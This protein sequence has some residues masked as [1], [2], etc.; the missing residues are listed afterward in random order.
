MVS[1]NAGACTEE[2]RSQ[3]M[4]LVEGMLALTS[5]VDAKLKMIEEKEH[6]QERMLARVDSN[7]R[8]AK[9]KV[10][11]NVGGRVFTASRD[12]F[13]RYENTYFHALFGCHCW[14]PDEDGTFFVDRDPTHF[15]RIMKSLRSGEPIDQTGLSSGEVENVHQEIEYY[16]LP[17]L[18]TQTL[19]RWNSERCTGG[20]VITEDGRTV[21][22]TSTTS[23][24]KWVLGTV[25]DLPCF[26]LRVVN[27]SGTIALGYSKYTD[28]KM[29]NHAQRTFLVSDRSNDKDV[30]VH[31]GDLQIFHPALKQDDIVTV[32]LDKRA[33][34]VS[35][36]V[37]GRY[38]GSH[39]SSNDSHFPCVILRHVGTSLSLED[40]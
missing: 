35:F 1:I 6:R 3:Y 16:Q 4:N 27:A 17:C 33:S 9:K 14:E 5:A 12:V 38:Y 24:A 19:L 26:Q 30:S 10:S 18:R 7:V 29:L 22:S 11:L 39:T 34:L 8:A 40:L 21:T 28:A 32:S 37:N 36:S 31:V 13:L 23:S 2:L 15:G 20:L 25:P